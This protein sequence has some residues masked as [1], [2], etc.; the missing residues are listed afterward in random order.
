MWV[1]DN[2]VGHRDDSDV[3]DR[4]E[5]GDPATVILS[6][7]DRQRSRVRT[8]TTDGRDLG[9]VVARDLA[10][11]DV[12]EADGELVVVELAAVDALVLDIDDI[13]ATDALKLGHALGNRHWD[14]ALRDSDALFPVPDTR[15]RMRDA[16]E[17]ELPD[18]VEIRFETVSP[19]LFDD[20]GDHSHGDHEHG[21]SG[22]SHAHSEH[23]HDNAG[24]RTIN[25]G[26]Q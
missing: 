15:E 1:A 8:E 11:G 4:L 16:V 14:L 12:L 7:T 10:D 21:T 19:T 3:A 2:Y 6:D 13:P 5:N 17:D 25:G 24:V 26:E 9:I 20:G 23:T 22:H 18:G